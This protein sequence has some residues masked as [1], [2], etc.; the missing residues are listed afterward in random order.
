MG[1]TGPFPFVDDT[2]W[3]MPYA[4]VPLHSGVGE[5]ARHGNPDNSFIRLLGEARRAKGEADPVGP[6][7]KFAASFF[8][9]P[10]GNCLVFFQWPS[11]ARIGVNFG[12][13]LTVVGDSAEGSFRLVCPEY[14]IKV[15]SDRKARPGWA[16]AS[17]VNESQKGISPISV[18]RGKRG[19]E[20]KREESNLGPW[21]QSEPISPM[22]LL[23]LSPFPPSEAS[24]ATSQRGKSPIW[25]RGGSQSQ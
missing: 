14:R 11:S 22:G 15:V 12:E 23:D 10:A 13:G 3:L 1:D 19:D 9:P 5:V 6:G 7:S 21:R 2:Q 16:V 20:P 25:D 17:P 18:L 4:K 8:V 24:G